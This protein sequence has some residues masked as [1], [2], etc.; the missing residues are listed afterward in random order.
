MLTTVKLYGVLAREFGKEHTFDISKPA[1]AI[2]A[3]LVNFPNF[4]QALIK[5]KYGVRVLQAET[6]LCIADDFH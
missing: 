4:E 6:G 5:L 2:Q 3:L 1:E